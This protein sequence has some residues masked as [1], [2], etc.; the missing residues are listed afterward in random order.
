MKLTD[1]LPIDKWIVFE[2]EIALKSGLTAGVYDIHGVRIT[3]YKA[4]ANQ[5]CPVV[6]NDKRGQ[7]FICA[8][9]HQNLASMAEQ[10]REAVLE[11]CDAGIAKL[12][13]PIFVGDEFVG[14]AGGCGLCLETGEVEPFM[15]AKTLEMDEE[16][17]EKLGQ[18]IGVLS[19]EKAQE[20]I[21]FIQEKIESIVA[22]YKAGPS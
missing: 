11:E 15:V 9:A 1:L 19:E 7:T 20:L 13:V 12:V 21:A 14:S 17:V 10:T 2:K 3:G 18:G 5:L 6:N 8:P 22:A 16:A 4:W